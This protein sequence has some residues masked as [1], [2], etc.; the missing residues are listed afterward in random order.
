MSQDQPN[1]GNS[2]RHTRNQTRVAAQ[3]P[4]EALTQTPGPS[5]NPDQLQAQNERLNAQAAVL[6]NEFLAKTR[7]LV[8]SELEN[9]LHCT[10]CS[11]TFLRGDNPEVP[12]RLDCGH[13]FGM[14]C[15]LKWLSPVSRNGN[16]S[17][18]NCRAPF[19]DDWDKMDFPEPRQIAPA[20]R[21][22]TAT[23]IETAQRRY[24]ETAR[25]L[26][27]IQETMGVARIG[28][29][30]RELRRDPEAQ[31]PAQEPDTELPIDILEER[32]QLR[33]D[34]A[35]NRRTRRE[36][37][38]ETE[39]RSIAQGAAQRP[40]EA[41]APAPAPAEAARPAED[42]DNGVASMFNAAEVDHDA[43]RQQEATNERKR[44]MWMQF[45]EGVV[46]TIEQSSDSAALANHDLALTIINMNDLDEFIAARASESPTWRR[47][48]QTFPRLHTEMVTRF[49]DFRPLPSVNIDAR[50][51]L[52]RLLASTRFNMTT[53]HKSRWYTRLSERVARGAA[54]TKHEAAVAQLTERV[55]DLSGP[56]RETAGRGRR[57]RGGS[58]QRPSS[59]EAS[60]VRRMEDYLRGRTSITARWE[61]AAS[62]DAALRAGAETSFAMTAVTRL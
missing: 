57:G 6:L 16:N 36:R 48:L 60:R 2:Q 58:G 20:R 14:N 27:E 30:E 50:I 32:I 8:S 62:V 26:E 33:A 24:E 40:A 19:F 43:Q 28:E 61:P 34:L 47:I 41:A 29:H 51:E 56:S 18:P 5:P 15:I 21:R 1:P 35:R 10:I 59:E 54:T 11:E 3:N 38:H 13:I 55:A 7:R 46:R 42:E 39:A 53:V 22:V 23:P 4:A 9:D 45:C 37:E 25:R 49:H 31:F 52:E 12:I 44:H 17:C